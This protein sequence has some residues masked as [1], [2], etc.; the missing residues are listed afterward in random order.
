MPHLRA[1]QSPAAVVLAIVG[2]VA[3]CAA[4][5]T[6]GETPRQTTP[7]SS[8][9]PSDPSTLT[10]LAMRSEE[11]DDV[12]ITVDVS[13]VR[14]DGAV[15]WRDRLSVDSRAP[16]AGIGVLAGPARTGRIVVG[17]HAGGDT[18]LRVVDRDGT[19]REVK[20]RGLALSGVLAA[21]G[22]A[23][24]AVVS[25]EAVTIER[26]QLDGD[27]TQSGL[28]S[29][30]SVPQHELMTGMDLLRITPDGRR[31]VI[32]VCASAGECSWEVIDTGSGAKS[33]IRPDGAGSMI[34]LSNDTMLVSDTRCAVGPCPFLLVDLTE[35]T[36][37]RWDPGRHNASLAIREDGTTV[38]L[39]DGS[40]VG[41]G[42]GPITVTDP[43]TMESRVLHDGT[44]PSGFLGL[45]RAGQREWAPPGWMVAAPPGT[46][47]GEVGGP[48]LI[49]L[50]DGFMV[51]LPQ[52]SGP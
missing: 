29:M 27:P 42:F 49:R 18:L 17:R 15:V 33:V 36:A 23:L 51:T 38:L 9:D 12:V 16:A 1:A 4:P 34:D 28:A 30:P 44:E 21:D 50:N 14:G 2:V 37:R 52:P 19:V 40:G 25:G 13:L 32:E 5:A 47:L 24:F 8:F 48:V 6:T 3:A 11:E 31:L 10:W 39:S 41:E 7:A 35:A 22:S 46:N 26:I 43:V 20:L 45:A